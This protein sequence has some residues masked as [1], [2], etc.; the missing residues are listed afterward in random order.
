[1]KFHAPRSPSHT[2]PRARRSER[3]TASA[4]PVPPP[5]C[6]RRPEPLRLRVGGAVNAPRSARARRAVARRAGRALARLALA[7]QPPARQRRR[8]RALPRAHR[9]AS[10]PPSRRGPLPRRPHA[11]PRQHDR[12]DDPACPV[13]RQVVPTEL[14]AWAFEGLRVDSLAEEAHAVVPGLVHRYPDRVLMLV[15]TECASYCRFCTRSRIVG[16][17]AE[18]FGAEQHEAQ[19]RYIAAHPEVRDVLL[20]GGDPWCCPTASSSGCWPACARSPTSRSS[21][22]GRGCRSSCRSASRP[23]SWRSSRATTRCGSTCTSTTRTS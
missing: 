9:R 4:D 2:G 1:M 19:L 8:A 16:Q 20:S 14:E 22:S 5:V 10:G 23:S 6:G 11:V 17:S 3:S 12:P 21:A 18:N 13:R 7:A 15:T